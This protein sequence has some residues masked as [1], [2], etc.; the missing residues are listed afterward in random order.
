M[1][2]RIR[3]AE[4]VNKIRFRYEDVIFSEYIGSYRYNLIVKYLCDKTLKVKYLNVLNYYGYLPQVGNY[5]LEGFRLSE[6]IFLYTSMRTNPKP[7]LGIFSTESMVIDYSNMNNYK[8]Y[9]YYYNTS[10]RQGKYKDNEY[11]SEILFYK[12]KYGVDKTLVFVFFD[13]NFYV[14]YKLVKFV[15]RTNIKILYLKGF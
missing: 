9:L 13:D 8:N 4:A 11:L 14:Q 6:S 2:L 7:N 15:E 5:E 3:N 10:D 1:Q 12:D